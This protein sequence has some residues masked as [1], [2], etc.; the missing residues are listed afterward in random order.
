MSDMNFNIQ[1]LD[2]TSTIAQKASEMFYKNLPNGTP[3]RTSYSNG[4]DPNRSLT[5]RDLQSVLA[6]DAIYR[7]PAFALQVANKNTQSSINRNIILNRRARC[8]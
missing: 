8:K 6:G 5:Q 3:L 4:G 7:S 1:D 2:S